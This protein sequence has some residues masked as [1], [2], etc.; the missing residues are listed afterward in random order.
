MVFL[1][2]M[3]GANAQD[4]GLDFDALPTTAPVSAGDGPLVPWL[5][6]VGLAGVVLLAARSGRGKITPSVLDLGR[7]PGGASIAITA[8]LL[9]YGLV[10]LLGAVS[11]ALQTRETYATAEEYFAYLTPARLTS[12]S[13]AHLMGISTLQ[14]FGALLYALSRRDGPGPRAVCT[15]AFVGVGADIGS[16]WLLKYRGAAWEVVSM[17]SGLAC[18]AAYLWMAVAVI[19]DVWRVRP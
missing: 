17:A 10:H 14:V 15:L 1:L 19:R 4:G 12:L 3:P 5:V 8:T 7:F 2:A 11:V 9:I 6:V 16:W 18:A 13:H